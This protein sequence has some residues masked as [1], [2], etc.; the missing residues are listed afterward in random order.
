MLG[1]F[2]VR[3]E[4]VELGTFIN[5]ALMKRGG[6]NQYNRELFISPPL[7][8]I[9]S[10]RAIGIRLPFAKGAGCGLVLYVKC[11]CRTVRLVKSQK[12]VC[13]RIES[14]FRRTI[15]AELPRFG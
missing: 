4:G 10:T 15:P 11:K 13:F 5:K 3:D 14:S 2:F 1:N 7:P 9:M 8:L 6:R 12:D